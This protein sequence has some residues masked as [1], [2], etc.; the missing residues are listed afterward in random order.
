LKAL[1]NFRIAALCNAN[2]MLTCKALALLFNLF[3]K[4]FSGCLTLRAEQRRN[5]AFIHITTYRTN[6][7]FHF[8]FLLEKING[9]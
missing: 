8:Y 5:F 3:Y 1:I 4:L 2:F 7:F 9:K 6:P